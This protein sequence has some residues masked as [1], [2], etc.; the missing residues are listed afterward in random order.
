M[1][2][3]KTNYNFKIILGRF[4]GSCLDWRCAGV[5]DDWWSTVGRHQRNLRHRWIWRC[6]AEMLG[7]W[8]NRSTEVDRSLVWCDRFNH[9]CLQ[10]AVFPSHFVQLSGWLQRTSFNLE[11]QHWGFCLLASN[12]HFKSEHDSAVPGTAHI[13]TNK[14]VG[15]PNL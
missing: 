2:N 9:P 10:F 14:M 3:F 8:Q 11:R 13:E 4:K 15:S 1:R 5:V 7:E 6:V 12:R